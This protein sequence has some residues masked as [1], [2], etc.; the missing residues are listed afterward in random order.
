[1][2]T[3]LASV[4]ALTML[5]AQA[6]E[7][8]VCVGIP[9][10]PADV[11]ARNEL[12]RQSS[13]ADAADVILVAEISTVRPVQL[14][15][16]AVGREVVLTPLY[17]LKGDFGGAS[18]TLR[19]YANS[20]CGLLPGWA[21]LHGRAGD[22]F[23]LFIRTGETRQSGVFDALDPEALVVPSLVPLLGPTTKPR[24]PDTARRPAS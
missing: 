3:Y 21:A 22:R 16:G 8:R 11:I 5:S 6:P 9:Y 18:F 15:G 19:H 12:R 17:A 14:N 2:S 23:V 7:P 24:T 13:N 4:F 10:T 1:M 20:D